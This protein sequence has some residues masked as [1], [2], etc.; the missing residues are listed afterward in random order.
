MSRLSVQL[1]KEQKK[2][3]REQRGERREDWRVGPTL[4]V[5]WRQHL[6]VLLI[7]FDHFNNLNHDRANLTYESKLQKLLESEKKVSNVSK[8]SGTILRIFF[9]LFQFYIQLVNK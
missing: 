7:L 8:I 3:K 2:G 4:Y 5:D 1:V 6:T 9:H